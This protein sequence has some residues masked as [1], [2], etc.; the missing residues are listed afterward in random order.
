MNILYVASSSRGSASYSNRVATDVLTELRDRN[1]GAT[2]TVRDL[3]REPLPHIDDDFVAATRGPVGSQTDEQRALL[4]RSDTLVDELLATDVVVI[5][6]PMINFTIPS[7][8]KSWVDYVARAGRTFRYSEKGPEGLVTGKQV[9]LV[10]ARGG[11]YAGN[12]ALDFQVPYLKSVLGFLGMNDVEVIEVEGT[13]FGPDAAEKAVEAANAKLHAQ[14]D[15]R[16][17][18]VAA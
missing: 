6:A 2:V 9:I 8:L 5:A 16:E 11:V 15:R 14:C 10:V 13:A 4:A 1:P 17:A 18:A 12:P 7:N 3:A